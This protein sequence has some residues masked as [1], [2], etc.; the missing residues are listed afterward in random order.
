MPLPVEGS[1]EHKTF[2]GEESSCVIQVLPILG[3]AEE[4]PTSFL[5]SLGFVRSH[6]NHVVW[7][8]DTRG[9]C[10]GIT[11]Y[12]RVFPLTFVFL[13]CSSS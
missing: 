6:I 1:Y 13:L 5:L 10:L 7:I 12:P 3:L 11:S 8:Y 4:T 2:H 9:C